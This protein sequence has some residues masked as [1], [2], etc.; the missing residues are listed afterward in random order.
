MTK[1]EALR[2][3]GEMLNRMHRF[4]IIPEDGENIQLFEDYRI[5]KDRGIKTMCIVETL[6][7]RYNKA[8]R[9]VYRLIKRYKEL[10]QDVTFE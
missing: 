1:Y 7:N 6:C 3:N 2:L 4:G 5:M 10:C 9:T 8:E